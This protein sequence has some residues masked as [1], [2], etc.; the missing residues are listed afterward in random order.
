M[1]RNVSPRVSCSLNTERTRI[2]PWGRS[3][4]KRG[5]LAPGTSRSSTGPSSG[6]RCTRPLPGTGSC[7]LEENLEENFGLVLKFPSGELKKKRA[8]SAFFKLSREEGSGEWQ[9]I[10]MAR[11]LVTEE[12][13][14]RRTRTRTHTT[15]DGTEAMLLNQVGAC[16]LRVRSVPREEVWASAGV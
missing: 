5:G 13:P 14:P 9:T 15:P 3:Y 10:P 1:V 12:P 11:G 8:A 7:D 4:P 2:F 6:P 16:A